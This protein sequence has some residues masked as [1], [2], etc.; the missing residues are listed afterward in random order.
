MKKIKI[1][2]KVKFNKIKFYFI[3]L[4]IFLYKKYFFIY[5]LFYHENL[6]IIILLL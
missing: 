1:F 4:F 5:I 6:C 2:K 3:Y